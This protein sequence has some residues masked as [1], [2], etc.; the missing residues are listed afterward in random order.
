MD[1]QCSVT[2]DKKAPGDTSMAARD[3]CR[4]RVG[5]FLCLGLEQALSCKAG[6][7]TDEMNP[8][9][10]RDTRSSNQRKNRSSVN[11]EGNSHTRQIPTDS[12]RPQKVCMRYD[13][14]PKSSFHKC[15][16]TVLSTFFRQCYEILRSSASGEAKL[17]WLN[18]GA[19][20]AGAAHTQ[21]H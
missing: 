13:N 15:K 4:V 5:L 8:G 19:G 14:H 1:S 6:F 7:S 21:A 17:M 2:C 20:A 11:Q 12:R 9:T 10:K 18:M 3:V 16:A